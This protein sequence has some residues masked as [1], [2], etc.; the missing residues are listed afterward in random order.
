MLDRTRKIALKT[1]VFLFLLLAST[2]AI[3]ETTMNLGIG[4]GQAVINI[5]E[6]DFDDGSLDNTTTVDS[7][8][9]AMTIYGETVF[10]RFLRFEF[11]LV[12]LLNGTQAKMEGTST[13]GTFWRSGNVEAE[14]GLA[15]LKLG[16]VFSIPLGTDKFKLLLKAGVAGW[17][18]GATLT[19]RTNEELDVA[20]GASPYGGVGLE[21]D[22]S[23]LIALRLQYEA[24][25]AQADSDYFD[26][27]YD[28]RYANSTFGVVFRF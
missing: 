11:G 14:Y 26:D 13:G 15:F 18:F 28:I 16:G 9:I 25:N 7:N 8:A 12:D 19:D 17:F 10:N 6:T 2:V 3:G 20:V 22:L 5:D 21:L 24:F 27:G 4:V 1:H 23:K